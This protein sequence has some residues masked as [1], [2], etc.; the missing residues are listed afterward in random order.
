[1]LAADYTALKEKV[2]ERCLQ[3]VMEKL[4]AITNTMN[5]LMEAKTTETKS[6]AGDKY[7]TGMAMI[8]NQEAQLLQQ[9]A[10]SKN[11]LVKLR[12]I[13]RD[14]AH[15]QVETG[16]LIIT[17]KEFFYVSAALGKITIDNT[18]VFAI[19]LES[20]LA[21]AMKFKT[22]GESINFRAITRTIVNIL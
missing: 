8:Q 10:E 12:Q 7:E 9:Q 16:A 14:V 18:E 1:M 11:M 19:S 22:V 17:N 13:D 20:P 3:L 5:S 4:N 6:S 15:E 2:H 21:Q